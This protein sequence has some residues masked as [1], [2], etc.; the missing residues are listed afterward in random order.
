[1]AIFFFRI[2][3]KENKRSKKKEKKEK[4]NWE[5]KVWTDCC[6]CSNMDSILI[7]KFI[8]HKN[9]FSNINLVCLVHVCMRSCEFFSGVKQEIFWVWSLGTSKEGSWIFSHKFSIFWGGSKFLPLQISISK[10]VPEPLIGYKPGSPEQ[11]RFL[12]YNEYRRNG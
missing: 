2:E 10:G 9:C 7:P 6:A 11:S 5:Q 3:K 4:K 1:M 8:T 12:Q